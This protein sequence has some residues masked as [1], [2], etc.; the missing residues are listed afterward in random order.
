MAECHDWSEDTLSAL[1]DQALKAYE[2]LMDSSEDFR[3]DAFQTRV[4]T[5]ILMLEDATRAVSILD[6]FSRNE[7]VHEMATPHLP[8]M[9]LPALLAQLQSKV[10]DPTTPRTET[11]RIAEIYYRD[12]LERIRDYDVMPDLKVPEIAQDPSDEETPESAPGKPDLAKM[13][14]ERVAKIQRFKTLKTLEARIKDLRPLVQ[15]QE[16]SIDDDV[17]REFHLKTL[18]SFAL[19]ALDELASFDMEKP[20]LVHMEKVRQGQAPDPKTLGPPSRPLKPVIIT[21]DAVQKEVFGLGYKNVPIFSIEEFYEQRVRDG[22][23]PDPKEVKKQQNSLQ[24]KTNADIKAEEEEEE[25]VKEEKE[26]QDD[27]EELARKRYMDDYKDEH[28]RGE[29]NRYNKG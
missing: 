13:E 3:T 2:S 8:L 12:F 19:N 21:R 1:F 16:G 20:I 27:P 15:A 18:T 5:T 17:L 14:R 23:F 7:R 28:K 26:E 22:W 6:I 25:R 29:G 24:D 9:L 11:I 4:K 10:F